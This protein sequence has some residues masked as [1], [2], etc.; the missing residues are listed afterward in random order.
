MNS[1]RMTE[2]EPEEDVGPGPLPQPHHPRYPQLVQ[3]RHQTE[4]E[5]SQAGEGEVPREI[6]AL[7]LLARKGDVEEDG[8]VP[9][10]LH[11]V[12]GDPV[13]EAGVVTANM[14]DGQEDG[15]VLPTSLQVTLHVDRDGAGPLQVDDVVLQPVTTNLVLS[16]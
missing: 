11:G 8:P 12:A 6:L 1:V 9:D 5:L 7:Q 14:V 3:D 2:T 4:P 10:L 15:G 16:T 13:D